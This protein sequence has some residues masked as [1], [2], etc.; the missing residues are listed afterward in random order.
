MSGE[1]CFLIIMTTTYHPKKFTPGISD[2]NWFK[3]G[4]KLPPESIA[5]MIKSKT[6]YTPEQLI[7][8]KKDRE[9][10]PV[11]ALLW[12]V[13]ARLPAADRRRP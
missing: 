2:K 10:L 7:Q 4:H 6:K 5:K 12:L 9:L 1:L 8:H 11:R 3:P 13:P